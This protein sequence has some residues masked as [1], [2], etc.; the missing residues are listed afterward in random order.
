MVK[1]IHPKSVD[2]LRKTLFDK[3][4]A[5]DI[6][7]AERDTLFN[8]FAVVNF[9]SICV[10]N[11]KLVDTEATTWVC[12]HQAISR[13]ITSTLLKKPIFIWDTEPHSLI[14]AFVNS[15][16]SLAK[17]SKLEMNHKFHDIATRIKEKLERVLSAIN[18][19][20]RQ[21]SNRNELQERSVDMG[22]D[23]ED[24]ISVSA[25]FLLTPKKKQTN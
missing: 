9:E 10:K 8:N 1:N 6:K 22:K 15:V 11:G 3:L 7:V 2:Q 13:S 5:F 12:K 17:K 4:R 21:L 20:T 14:S 23:D 18:T 24:E 19:K 25:Q 16:E